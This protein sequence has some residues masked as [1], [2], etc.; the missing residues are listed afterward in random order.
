MPATTQAGRNSDHPISYG[1]AHSQKE[2]EDEEERLQLKIIS[3]ASA[4]TSADSQEK[5]ARDTKER[6]KA[7][8][9]PLLRTDK[10][11]D[12][13]TSVDAQLVTLKGHESR[14][15][16]WNLAAGT[17]LVLAPINVPVNAASNAAN[18]HQITIG[19]TDAISTTTGQIS[20]ML[21]NLEFARR[22]E[23]TLTYVSYLSKNVE[24][25]PAEEA[26]HTE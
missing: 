25:E 9:V 22:I 4:R 14:G 11:R 7:D 1:H 18:A 15:E 13:G 5:S 16:M 10:A 21:A 20:Q 6:E 3:A 26:E 19:M 17:G 12:A 24:G 8:F 2:K 23:N